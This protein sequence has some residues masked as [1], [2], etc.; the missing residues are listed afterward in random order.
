MA[1]ER[2]R[3]AKFLIFRAGKAGQARAL[4]VREVQVPY[5]MY[6]ARILYDLFLE[7]LEVLPAQ[8]VGGALL[9]GLVG[10]APAPGA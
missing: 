1:C 3:A 7:L 6:C 9:L 5:A 2:K 8:W 4:A 10:S